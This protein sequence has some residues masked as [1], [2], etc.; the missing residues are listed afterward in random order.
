[1]VLKLKFVIVNA[2]AVAHSD[3]PLLKTLH[4][5]SSV[6]NLGRDFNKLIEGCPILEE[7]QTIDLR[8]FFPND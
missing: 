8:F 2:D 1:V 3:F 5:D 6:F 4:L 7:L